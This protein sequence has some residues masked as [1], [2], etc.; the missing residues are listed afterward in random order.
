MTPTRE[1]VA[2]STL[3][4]TAVAAVLAMLVGLDV[5]RLTAEQ[6]GVVIGAVVAVVALAG[7]IWARAR[8]TPV[9]DPRADN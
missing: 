3:I 5:I 8:V 2:L 6:T 4:T 1:P 9:A 7:G